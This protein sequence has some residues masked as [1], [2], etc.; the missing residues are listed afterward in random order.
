MCYLYAEFL[1]FVCKQLAENC[2]WKWGCWLDVK[3]VYFATWRLRAP[4]R[5]GYR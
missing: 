1:I 3:L 5:K 4:R 2:N